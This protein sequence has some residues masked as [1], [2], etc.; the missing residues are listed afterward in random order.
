MFVFVRLL[1]APVLHCTALHRHVRGEGI[2]RARH[3]ADEGEA[4]SA[5]RRA[6]AAGAALCARTAARRG[7]RGRRARASC[8]ASG[9]PAAS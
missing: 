2:Q 5:Q 8:R 6:Q 1:P 3:G 7:R 9:R 4:H